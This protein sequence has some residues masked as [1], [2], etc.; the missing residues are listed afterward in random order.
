[1]TYLLY[2]ASDEP[3]YIENVKREIDDQFE[4][5]NKTSYYFIKKSVRKILRSVK[6]Y[7][8]YSKVKETEVELLLY[9]CAELKKMRPPMT[10]SVTLHNLYKRQIVVIKKSLS[11]LHEDLRFD[12]EL[13]LNEIGES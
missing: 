6:K 3:G 12:Y 2:D 1:M 9:F 4:Q 7:I 8:R 5:I 10:R 13:E 11:T